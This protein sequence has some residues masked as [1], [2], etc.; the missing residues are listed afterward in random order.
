RPVVVGLREHQREMLATTALDARP[1]H[2]VVLPGPTA[3]PFLTALAVS[4]AF[5]G[6]M[7]GQH[8]VPIGGAL[9]F[10][11]LTVW[12]WPRVLP[13]RLEGEEGP[14]H[15]LSRLESEREEGA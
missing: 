8:W 15:R 11:A 9:T 13:P 2:R 6:V 1:D 4:V 3:I 14:E 10:V 12:N 5:V 7:F